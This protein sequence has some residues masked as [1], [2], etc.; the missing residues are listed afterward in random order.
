[1]NL[2]NKSLNNLTSK[3]KSW[4]ISDNCTQFIIFFISE[5]NFIHM[6][7]CMRKE[8]NLNYT[9]KNNVV[10]QIKVIN[11]LTLYTCMTT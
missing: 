4:E 10:D 7:L 3:K 5:I 2:L 6:Q 1:M 8:R 11:E 9:C